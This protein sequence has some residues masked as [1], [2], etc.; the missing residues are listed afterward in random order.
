MLALQRA[1][2]VIRYTFELE[3]THKQADDAFIKASKVKDKLRKRL[4]GE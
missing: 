3:N 4:A 1:D 2:Y